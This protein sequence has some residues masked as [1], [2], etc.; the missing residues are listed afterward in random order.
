MRCPAHTT[1]SADFCRPIPT[2]C[3]A[4]STRQS[5]SSP[6]VRRVTFVP[7]TRRIYGHTFR[8]ISGFGYFGSLA[9][10]WTPHMRFLFVRPGLC[11]QL[12][13]DFAP[14]TLAVRLTVPITRARKGLAPPSHRPDTT[15]A[16]SRQSMALR[17]MPGARKKSARDFR[18]RAD[19]GSCGFV[20]KK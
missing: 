19:K 11:L 4:G 8:M 2:P 17:A 3:D 12:P 20:T 10:M 7:Y 1:A 13:S 16:K 6:R 14:D 9:Q 5:G 18:Q 15:P